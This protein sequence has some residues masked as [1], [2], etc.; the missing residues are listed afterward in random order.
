MQRQAGSW[1]LEEELGTTTHGSG[2]LSHRVWVKGGKAWPHKPP[3]LCGRHGVGWGM[4]NCKGGRQA[5]NPTHW[6]TGWG[7]ATTGNWK[8]TS[9]GGGCQVQAGE[10]LGRLGVGGALGRHSWGLP[11]QVGLGVNNNPLPGWVCRGL[12]GHVHH[13]ASP[14][15]EAESGK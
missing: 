15:W 13:P 3:C 8:S 10:G 2:S 4:Y 14:V 11:V 5:Q 1:G 9:G 12:Q 7:F 6:P